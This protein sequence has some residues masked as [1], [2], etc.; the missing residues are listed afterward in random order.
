MIPPSITK[1]GTRP[2]LAG[3]RV[4]LASFA[5]TGLEPS[6]SDRGYGGRWQLNW[7]GTAS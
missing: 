2:V 5:G 7:T 1:R 3:R 4:R 6:T